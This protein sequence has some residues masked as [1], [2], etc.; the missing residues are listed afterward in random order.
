M[1]PNET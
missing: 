1:K